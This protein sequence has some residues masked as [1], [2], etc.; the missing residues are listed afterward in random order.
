MAVSRSVATRALHLVLLLAVVHQLL[1]SQFIH[2]PH[3]GEA[4][5]TLWLAH[6]YVGVTALLT[7]AA[8][9]VWTLVRH[10]ETPVAALVPWFSR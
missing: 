5:G 6:Q 10:R 9:W 7:V 2:R 8:F 4:P 3:K 1:S